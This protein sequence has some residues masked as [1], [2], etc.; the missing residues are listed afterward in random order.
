MSSKAEGILL[1]CHVV[2]PRHTAMRHD[3]HTG[4]YDHYKLRCWASGWEEEEA[5]RRYVVMINIKI[6]TACSFFRVS[7]RRVYL[8]HSVHLLPALLRPTWGS[9]LPS[10]SAGRN[11]NQKEECSF[12]GGVFLNLFFME[13]VSFLLLAPSAKLN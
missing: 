6:F 13:F 3:K 7:F 5:R 12:S 2:V 10:T 9:T 8:W 4:R 1:V 11:L